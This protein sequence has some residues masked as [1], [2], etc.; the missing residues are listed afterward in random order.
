MSVSR[1]YVPNEYAVYLSP[2]DRER[3]AD[4]EEPS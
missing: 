4:Y 3:F 1:T 2:E